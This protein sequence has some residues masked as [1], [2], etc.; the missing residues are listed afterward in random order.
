MIRYKILFWIRKSSSDGPIPINCRITVS[1]DARCDFRIGKSIPA[2]KW[3]QR[4]QKAKGSGF[5]SIDINDKIQEIKNEI[6]ALIDAAKTSKEVVTAKSIVAKYT[7]TPEECQ[8][9]LALYDK[10]ITPVS[11]MKD[12]AD[13]TITVMESTRQLFANFFMWAYNLEDINATG[14]TQKFWEDFQ[15]YCVIEKEYSSNYILLVVSRISRL[16]KHLQSKGFMAANPYSVLTIKRDKSTHKFLEYEDVMAIMSTEIGVSVKYSEPLEQILKRLIIHH[17]KEGDQII[18]KQELVDK[19]ILTRDMFWGQILSGAAYTDFSLLS[20]DNNILLDPSGNKILQYA[21]IKTG[22]ISRQTIG[23]DLTRLINKYAGV[24]SGKMFP[25]P[26]YQTYRNHLAVLGAICGI[27]KKLTTHVGR[28]TFGTHKSEDGW[29]LADIAAMMGHSDIKSTAI[30][31]RVT[32]K[33][34]IMKHQEIEDRKK[35]DGLLAREVLL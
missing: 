4:A 2:S 13:G 23:V 14:I 21:R 32:N 19:I 3:D 20:P 29:D 27:K 11:K 22:E 33:R 30:Y 25:V 18:L 6:K 5:E 16:L 24:R 34:L 8:T 28:H 10:I 35:N 15:D 12:A 9:F 17:T 7:K 26:E 1:G 31:S